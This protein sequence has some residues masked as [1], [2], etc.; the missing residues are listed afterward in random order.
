MALWVEHHQQRQQE[1]EEAE[2]EEAGAAWRVCRD[3]RWGWSDEDQ[4]LDWWGSWWVEGVFGSGIWV[5]LRGDSWALQHLACSRALLLH[6]SEVYGWSAEG[7]GVFACRV[8]ESR[9]D[10]QLEDIQS[11]YVNIFFFGSCCVAEKNF[12]EFVSW[13]RLWSDLCVGC[14]IFQ[15]HL[16][17][18]CNLIFLMC[19]VDGVVNWALWFL[20]QLF[21]FRSNYELGSLILFYFWSNFVFYRWKLNFYFWSNFLFLEWILEWI[22]YFWTNF[23]LPEWKLNWVLWFWKVNFVWNF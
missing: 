22:F 21:I 4:E 10:C 9:S 14:F 11:R 19:S 23:F 6:E 1:E 3:S 12:R 8:G 16:G 13:V 2:E 15:V 5:Q 7:A 18:Q 20:N 17:G